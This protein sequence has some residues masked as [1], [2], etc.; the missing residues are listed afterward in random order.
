[1][2]EGVLVGDIEKLGQ[3]I[4]GFGGFGILKKIRLKNASI[5]YKRKRISLDFFE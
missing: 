4:K 2:K 1:M 3:L 5:L